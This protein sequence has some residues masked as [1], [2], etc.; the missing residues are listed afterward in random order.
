MSN[1]TGRLMYPS[2]VPFLEFDF[3]VNKTNEALLCAFTSHWLYAVGHWI[4]RSKQFSSFC[5]PHGFKILSHQE[6]CCILYDGSCTRQQHNLKESHFTESSNVLSWNELRRIIESHSSSFIG[7]PWNLHHV[8]KG[9]VQML[10]ED[11]KVWGCDYL[12]DEPVPVFLV[13]YLTALNKLSQ[14]SEKHKVDLSLARKDGEGK[15]SKLIVISLIIRGFLSC[16]S[17]R[18]Y[19]TLSSTQYY[20][21]SFVTNRKWCCEFSVWEIL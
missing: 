18:N 20:T 5:L 6:E 10:L 19:S 21:C 1:R 15:W 2:N 7:Q 9:I 16:H 4:S 13:W 8:S 11:C 12:S 14:K 17:L 3:S